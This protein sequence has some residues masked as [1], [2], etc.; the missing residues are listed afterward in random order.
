[1]L[2]IA[3]KK[4]ECFV[5]TKNLDGETNLKIKEIP[6]LL[7]VDKRVWNDPSVDITV[8]YIDPSKHLEMF[9]GNLQQSS[10]GA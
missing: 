1:M 10:P 4:K 7:R 3:E 5:E 9:H 2:E 6:E 8:E